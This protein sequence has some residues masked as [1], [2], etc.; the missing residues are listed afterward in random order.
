[1]EHG[2]GT[3]G[4]WDNYNDAWGVNSNMKIWPAYW[5]HPDGVSGEEFGLTVYLKE[6]G[7]K[8]EVI[9]TCYGDSTSKSNG[10]NGIVV[11]KNDVRYM[12][13]A[14]VMD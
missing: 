6:S 3:C 11:R 7:N 5:I 10:S 8:Y 14:F 13:C 1:M 2:I 4:L 12:E 9:F